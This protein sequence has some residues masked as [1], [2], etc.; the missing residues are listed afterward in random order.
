MV[1]TGGGSS[2]WAELTNTF[3]RSFNFTKIGAINWF[4]G[5]M[6]KG[7]RQM[8]HTMIKTDLIVEVHDARIPLSGRNV[9]FRSHVTGTGRPHILVLNKKDLV[10]SSQW[11]QENL[12]SRILKHDG[13]LSDVIFTNCKD[14]NCKGLKSVRIILQLACHSEIDGNTYVWVSKAARHHY[15]HQLHTYS[16]NIGSTIVDRHWPQDVMHYL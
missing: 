4:P 1:L 11:D 3:R 8:E 9:N 12:K 7:L 2:K 10:I 5:H 16:R 13:N 15:G 6:T 14:Q